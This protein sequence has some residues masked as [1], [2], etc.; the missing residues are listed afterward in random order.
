[1]NLKRTQLSIIILLAVCF[2][3]QCLKEETPVEIDYLDLSQ[4]ESNCGTESIQLN[5]CINCEDCISD[6]RLNNI[7]HIAFY[8]EILPSRFTTRIVEFKIDSTFNLQESIC[9]PRIS[10]ADSSYIALHLV[11]DGDF[12]NV[13]YSVFETIPTNQSS[14]NLEMAFTDENLWNKKH[15][16]NLDLITNKPIPEIQPFS[17]EIGII[18]SMGIG[19]EVSHIT[20][21]KLIELIN[22]LEED[23]VGNSMFS[24]HAEV[25]GGIYLRIY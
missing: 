7:S 10:I 25:C 15:C 9:I 23:A 17:G 5:L 11:E 8:A 18:G 14:V 13:N 12:T 16:T 2:F 19:Y 20:D 3:I 22:E 1:M 4:I 24:P 21:S 6:P